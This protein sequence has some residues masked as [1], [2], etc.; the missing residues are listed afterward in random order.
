MPKYSK[1]RSDKLSK[2]KSKRLSKNKKQSKRSNNRKTQNKK[3]KILYKG[4]GSPSDVYTYSGNASNKKNNK[5]KIVK[6]GGTRPVDLEEARI[7]DRKINGGDL[8][9]Y[10]RI[11]PEI[12]RAHV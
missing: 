10:N 8:K 9:I 12:G 2:K 6:C 11:A 5:C 4:G 3:N 7:I 1:K